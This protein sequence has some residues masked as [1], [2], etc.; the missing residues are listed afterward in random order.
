[1]LALFIVAIGVFVL[2]FAFPTP[3]PIVTRFQATQLFS[4]DGDGRRDV[5][6]IDVRC[7]AHGKVH[8]IECN[9]LPGLSPGFSDLCVI[10]ESTGMSHR[11]LIGEILAPALRR[12]GFRISRDL[13]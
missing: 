4:P 5:A 9:P 2:P 12:G 8:F 6:R 13:A 3:P 1:M 10:A 7:D 11:D